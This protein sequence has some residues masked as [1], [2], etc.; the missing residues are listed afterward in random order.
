MSDVGYYTY[1]ARVLSD[2]TLSK[3]ALEEIVILFHTDYTL[4]AV[5]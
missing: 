2:L 5:C 3:S 1:I 4:Y